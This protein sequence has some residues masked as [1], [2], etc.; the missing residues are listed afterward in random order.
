MPTYSNIYLLP[1]PMLSTYVRKYIQRSENE[2][3]KEK[4]K[5]KKNKKTKKRR[6][7][8]HV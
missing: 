4:E 7:K 2:K 6:Q 8:K 1:V 3:E 5:K